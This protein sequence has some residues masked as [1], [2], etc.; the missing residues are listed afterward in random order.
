MTP[1]SALAF[2]RATT[3]D[4]PAI[5]AMLADDALGATR[6]RLESPLPA[7]YLR[8]FDEIDADPNN[9]LVVACLGDDIVGVLQLTFIPYLTHQGSRRALIEGVRVARAHRGTGLG[10]RLF[11]WAI[12]RARERGCRM[13]QLTTDKSRLDA[14]RF[15]EALGFVA[16]HEGMKLVL[17]LPA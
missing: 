2:R 16:S 4:V 3:E 10:T 6:E 12:A 11:E 1:P 17:D 14:K 9:E 15:Y 13:V 5:V 7:S 8:A